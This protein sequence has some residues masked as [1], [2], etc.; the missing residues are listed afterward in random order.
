MHPFFCCFVGKQGEIQWEKRKNKYISD[1]KSGIKY[2]VKERKKEENTK[3]EKTPVDELI[4]LVG[5]SLIEY[6]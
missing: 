2:T 4:D 5:D 3:Q 6:K 1:I